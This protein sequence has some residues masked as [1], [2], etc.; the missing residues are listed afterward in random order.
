MHGRIQANEV[1]GVSGKH[2]KEG[3]IVQ[4]CEHDRAAKPEAVHGHDALPYV[5]TVPSSRPAMHRA[6]RVIKCGFWLFFC[7]SL[8]FIVFSFLESTF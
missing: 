6:R 7:G 5:G 2:F 1:L 4:Q 8:S 3:T